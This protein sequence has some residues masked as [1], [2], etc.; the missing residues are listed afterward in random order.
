MTEQ[1]EQTTWTENDYSDCWRLSSPE[2][3]WVTDDLTVEDIGVPERIHVEGDT[4]VLQLAHSLVACD[5]S[6]LLSRE[7]PDLWFMVSN[8]MR[9][10]VVATLIVATTAYAPSYIKRHPFLSYPLLLP[11]FHQKTRPNYFLPDQRGQYESPLINAVLDLQKCALHLF[12]VRIPFDGPVP[13][14]ADLFLLQYAELLRKKIYQRKDGKADAF[15]EFNMPYKGGRGANYRHHFVP[16]A[17]VIY[18]DWVSR[19]FENGLIRANMHFSDFVS[20]TGGGDNDRP[21][22]DKMT[23]FIDGK[24]H[25]RYLNSD[26][27]LSTLMIPDPPN[28]TNGWFI[29]IPFQAEYHEEYRQSGYLVHSIDLIYVP[30]S[31]IGRINPA[32]VGLDSCIIV[33]VDPNGDLCFFTPNTAGTVIQNTRPMPQHLPASLYRRKM[34]G[35]WIVAGTPFDEDFRLGLALQ[36]TS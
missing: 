17:V 7:Q 22:F 31:M 23:R 15:R 24:I 14:S 27:Q 29:R 32:T 4:R 16:R 26:I 11:Y 19:H 21:A 28:L 12:K 1:Q 36:S 35:E 30:P 5:R 33:S 18:D 25:M 13:L 9:A 6:L 2:D 3:I 20:P 34:Y 8:D 10:S